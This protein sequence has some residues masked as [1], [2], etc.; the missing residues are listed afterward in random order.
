MWIGKRK[1]FEQSMHPP[2]PTR[3]RVD[4][5]ER[6]IID[7]YKTHGSISK[8][9]IEM[10]KGT[11]WKNFILMALCQGS[12]CMLSVLMYLTIKDSL[13]DSFSSDERTWR[14][15]IYL[16]LICVCQILGS[17]LKNY[18][19]CDLSRLSVRL[20]CGVIFTVY[21]K[22]M[23]ISVLNPSEHTEGN[24]LNYINVDAQKLED[25]ITKLSLLMEAI[26]LI[27]FG[28]SI[29]IWLI[30]YNIAACIISFFALTF[31]T[32]YLYKVIFKYEVMVAIAKDKRTR[33]LKNV[34]NNV[35]YIKTRVWEN[36][37]H[38]K[39]FA[40]REAEL[41]AID[42]SNFIFVVIVG[43]AWVNPTTSY[44]STYASMLLFGYDFDI[45]TILA[46]VRIFA[47]IL[48][49]MGYIP[50]VI[51]FFI[52][53]GVSLDRINVYL[54]TTELN[55]TW[56]NSQGTSAPLDTIAEEGSDGS[57][58]KQPFAIE[59]DLGNFYWNKMDE[60]L[61]KKRRERSRKKRVKIRKLN[62]QGT[63]ADDQN[64]LANAD[65]QSMRSVSV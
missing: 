35:K 41:G 1:S 4:R 44:L 22:L 62:N 6:R 30:S 50:T 5:S 2:A 15:G 7:L 37:Y 39:I 19:Y 36:F 3:D 23:R 10:Y 58:A 56:I 45:A 63:A 42:K 59:L 11:I 49:G 65:N 48:K 20:K 46:Y 8:S 53:L 13:N 27:I 17:F 57:N 24:I 25:A 12:L 40:S 18:I 55:D 38:S 31:F 29:C 34:V 60:K 26:W 9:I 51:Q 64:L 28:F 14:L 54:D 43:L 61:M 33:L 21:K 47:S 52:E 32:M 16:G